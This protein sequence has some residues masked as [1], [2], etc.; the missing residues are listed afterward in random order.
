MY[1]NKYSII[2]VDM[3]PRRKRKLRNLYSATWK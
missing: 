2:H 1:M 3:P